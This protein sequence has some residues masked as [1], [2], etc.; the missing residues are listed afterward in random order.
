M[1]LDERGP[2]FGPDQI[3]SMHEAFRV[4]CNRMRLKGTKSA[5]IIELVAIKIVQLARSGEFNTEKLV[6]GVLSELGTIR[7]P[8][9]STSLN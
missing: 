9:R 6:E 1:P 5:P 7:N 2:L 8:E 4:V 3:E